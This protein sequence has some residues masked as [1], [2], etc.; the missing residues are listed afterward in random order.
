MLPNLKWAVRE[1]ELYLKNSGEEKIVQLNIF[2]VRLKKINFF[3][4]V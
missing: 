4:L 2:L 1:A 3:S